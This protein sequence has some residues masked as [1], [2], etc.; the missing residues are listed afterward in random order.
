MFVE[1]L[2]EIRAF[3]IGQGKAY[4]ELE[5]EKWLIRVMFLADIPPTLANLIFFCR[6]QN[7]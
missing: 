1:C 2:V 3:L 5:D 4:P 7:K 6:V